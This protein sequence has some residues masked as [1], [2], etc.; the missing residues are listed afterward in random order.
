MQW[1]NI[2]KVT[3]V[4]RCNAAKMMIHRSRHCIV[5]YYI[6]CEYNHR[7][8]QWLETFP[9]IIAHDFFQNLQ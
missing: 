4:N 8:L 2:E 6:I 5:A 3:Q 1:V 7:R 9:F